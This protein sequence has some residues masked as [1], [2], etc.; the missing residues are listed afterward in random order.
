M[1]QGTINNLKYSTHYPNILASCDEKGYISII[2]T[3]APIIKTSSTNNSQNNNTNISKLIDPIYY[4][5][6]HDNS[7]F[8]IDWSDSDNRLL[9]ASADQ[10]GKIIN[11]TSN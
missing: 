8:G 4:E 2:D 3:N 11:F 5:Q 10:K 6:C 9:T 1:Q 7:I